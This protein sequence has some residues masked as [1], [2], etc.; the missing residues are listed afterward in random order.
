VQGLSIYVEKPKIMD[1]ETIFGFMGGCTN[2]G[3]GLFRMLLARNP[4]V[5]VLPTEGPNLTC[6]LPSDDR[7]NLPRRLFAL[8]PDT[9]RLTEAD[10]PGLNVDGILADWA[11]HWDVSKRVLFEKCPANATRMRLLQA[12]F[13]NTYFIGLIRNPYAVSE[14]IRRRRGHPLKDCAMQWHEA[15]RLMLEDAA[16]LNHF[17]LLR[18]EDLTARVNETMRKVW[19]FFG[20]PPVRLDETEPLERHNI[21]NVAQPVRNMNQLSIDNLSESDRRMVTKM[22]WPFAAQ[23]GYEALA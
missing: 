7:C 9:Y 16:P 5:S 8:Y 4:N 23:F 1:A 20:I 18:Y 3:T 11:K 10:L 19:S 6:F 12:A 14:G 22:C 2:S 15:N 17:L 21:T 13:P